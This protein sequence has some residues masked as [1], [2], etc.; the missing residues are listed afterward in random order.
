MPLQII[1][2]VFKLRVRDKL[3]PGKDILPAGVKFKFVR[4]FQTSLNSTHPHGSYK[5]TLEA[6]YDLIDAQEPYDIGLISAGGYGMPIAQH[7]RQRGSSA[8]Y[9]GGGMQILFGI[10]GKILYNKTLYQ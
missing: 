6:T 8:V 4:T 1:L 7:I 5:E 10:K 9:M 2:F 3:F